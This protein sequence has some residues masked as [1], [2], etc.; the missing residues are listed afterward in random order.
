MEVSFI[1]EVNRSTW[2]KPRPAASHRQILSHIVVSSAPRHEWDSSSQLKWRYSLIVYQFTI[3][4]RPRQPLLLK[5]MRDC[6]L[7][8]NRNFSDI[9]WREQV[10]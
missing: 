4:S 6:C 10:K 2:R 7:T 3:Q 1:G 5:G 9:A 8:Q